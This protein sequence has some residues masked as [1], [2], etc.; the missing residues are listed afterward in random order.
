MRK[1]NSTLNRKILNLR[2][3]VGVNQ[4]KYKK[5]FPL[6]P[7]TTCSVDS[8]DWGRNIAWC[9]LRS[10]QAVWATLSLREVRNGKVSERKQQTT[11]GSVWKE[12][13]ADCVPYYLISSIYRCTRQS[14]RVETVPELKQWQAAWAKRASNRKPQAEFVPF[15]SPW[16]RPCCKA[17][18]VSTQGLCLVLW[19]P[20]F[21]QSFLTVLLRLL[22]TPGLG[23]RT[24]RRNTVDG[25]DPERAM[26]DLY[27]SA[28]ISSHSLSWMRRCRRENK[29]MRANNLDKETHHYDFQLPPLN[30]GTMR[31]LSSPIGG[32]RSLF[33]YGVQRCDTERP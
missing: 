14:A 15:D 16:E 22:D 32:T 2:S 29:N 33:V 26:F 10:C 24:M 19:I 31:S 3:I 12:Q 1:K 7:R 6:P 21:H 17:R 23:N 25:W 5:L 28:P 13:S 27:V 30:D 4:K 20:V 9:L 11:G 8:L 18:T